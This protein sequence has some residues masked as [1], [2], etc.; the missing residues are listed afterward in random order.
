LLADGWVTAETRAA[1]LAAL[2]GASR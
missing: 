1:M 2:R